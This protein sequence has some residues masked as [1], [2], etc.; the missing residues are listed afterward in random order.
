MR[1]WLI[2]CTD[3]VQSDGNTS[4]LITSS[5]W[6]LFPLRPCFQK[7]NTLSCRQTVRT[8]QVTQLWVVISSL[9]LVMWFFWVFFLPRVSM[10]KPKTISAVSSFDGSPWRV[11][12]LTVSVNEASQSRTKKTLWVRAGWRCVARVVDDGVT[13]FWKGLC[14]RKLA[15]Q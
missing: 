14:L 12:I 11:T 4:E 7:A 3:Q 8:C 6:K 2:K 13:G 10:G 1:V 15:T 9:A 5:E